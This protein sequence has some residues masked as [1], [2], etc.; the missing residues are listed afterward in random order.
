MSD[1]LNTCFQTVEAEK[2]TEAVLRLWNQFQYTFGDHRQCSF[3]TDNNLFQIKSG[4]IFSILAARHDN[5]AICQNQ[6]QPHDII[7]RYTVFHSTHTACIGADIS[8]DGGFLFARIRW[9]E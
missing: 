9:I 5:G 6:F 4:C 8:A 7:S 2:D 3:G 1:A